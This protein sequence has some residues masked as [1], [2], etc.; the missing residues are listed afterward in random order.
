MAFRKDPTIVP[1]DLGPSKVRAAGRSQ[2]KTSSSIDPFR[3]CTLFE[4]LSQP[5]MKYHSMRS[6]KHFCILPTNARKTDTIVAEKLKVK[7]MHESG[8]L[9]SAGTE[10]KA[11]VQAC[12]KIGYSLVVVLLE[13]DETPIPAQQPTPQPV[14]SAGKPRLHPSMVESII[15]HRTSV[16]VPDCDVTVLLYHPGESET[17]WFGYFDG[18]TPSGYL[19]RT[20]DGGVIESSVLAWAEFPAGPRIAND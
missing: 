8:R 7:L 10:W 14:V 9:N 5:G 12:E 15:W 2:R 1:D 19:W 16:S 3:I 18:A 11:C 4:A 17:V 20:V 13:K 6:S